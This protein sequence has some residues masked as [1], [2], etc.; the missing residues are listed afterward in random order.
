MD[1]Q[2]CDELL[3]AYR[4][5]TSLFTKAQRNL[6]GMVGDDFQVALEKLRLLYQACLDAK[7]A[8]TEHWRHDHSDLSNKA[9]FS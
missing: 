9:A 4:L 1:C 5:A 6:E 8:V 7:A 2:R 3:A